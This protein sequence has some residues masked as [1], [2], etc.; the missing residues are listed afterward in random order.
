MFSKEDSYSPL[1]YIVIDPQNVWIASIILRQSEANLFNAV[2]VDESDSKLKDTDISHSVVRRVYSLRALSGIYR[3]R[4]SLECTR[5]AK[6]LFDVLMDSQQHPFV[7]S[8]AATQLLEWH[9]N[10]MLAVSLGSSR[11][12]TKMED[13]RGFMFLKK[14]YDDLFRS[15]AFPVAK[16]RSIEYEFWESEVRPAIVVAL[17]RAKDARGLPHGSSCAAILHT[18]DSSDGASDSDVIAKVVSHAATEVISALSF[19]TRDESLQAYVNDNSASMDNDALRVPSLREYLVR[20]VGAVRLRL[21]FDVVCSSPSHIVTSSCLK[22]LAASEVHSMGKSNTPFTVI[23]ALGGTSARS[24]VHFAPAEVLMRGQKVD[25]SSLALSVAWSENV[26]DAA[27]SSLIDIN[28]SNGMIAGDEDYSVWMRSICWIL[29]AAMDDPCPLVCRRVV[30]KLLDVHA[31]TL[32]KGEA[33]DDAK[34][35]SSGVFWPLAEPASKLRMRERDA[36][37]QVV[38]VMWSIL[39][40]GS[41]FD[42]RLRCAVY[43]LW[44]CI[45]G[46]SVPEIVMY[47]DASAFD[48]NQNCLAN[49]PFSDWADLSEAYWAKSQR[50]ENGY[51]PSNDDSRFLMGLRPDQNPSDESTLGGT[52]KKKTLFKIK[53]AAEPGLISNSSNVVH[54]AEESWN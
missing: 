17:A 10:F 42:A 18:L 28:V 3:K 26:R 36:A 24:S 9:K 13:S 47:Y 38:E 14:A 5:C 39:N 41:E 21:N 33:P 4:R 19:A 32:K 45:W 6:R 15:D 30:N 43:Q 8:E 20:L 23:Y 51:V 37:A 46:D 40:E 11:S 1:R 25:E 49:L 29:R 12:T 16:K 44:R 22:A 27:F 7:R 35:P 31:C 54:S 53:V 48:A 34:R 50:V 2:C 52:G